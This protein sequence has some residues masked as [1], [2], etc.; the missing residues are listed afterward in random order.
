MRRDKYCVLIV[1]Y[2]R[3]SYVQYLDSGREK[4]KNYNDIK[5]VLDKALT[6]FAAKAGPLKH[7]K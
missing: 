1:V 2:P 6:G 4:P 7:E 3:H 5:F